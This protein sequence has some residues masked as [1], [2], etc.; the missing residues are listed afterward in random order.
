MNWN[1]STAIASHYDQSDLVQQQALEQ[2]QETE[3]RSRSSSA[4]AR[5]R[6]TSNLG[7]VPGD[8]NIATVGTGI[9]VGME[10]APQPWSFIQ[11]QI[12][13]HMR[14][15]S[16]DDDYNTSYHRLGGSYEDDDDEDMSSQLRADEYDEE[17]IRRPDPV[18]QQRLISGRHPNMGMDNALARAD[19]PSVE[20]IYEPPRHISFPGS[21]QE[22]KGLCKD[23][24]K[25]LIVNI[26]SH[27]EFSSHMLN[28]D[29]WADE[30][31]ESI[32]R[33]SFL[34][35][36]RGHTSDEGRMFMR[37]YQMSEAD[38]PNISIIDSRTGARILTLKG[39]ISH[40]DLSILLMEFLES[41][42]V[43]GTDA[44]VVRHIDTT[45]WKS[46][47]KEA[48]STHDDDSPV[49]IDEDEASNDEPAISSSPIAMDEQYNEPEA[50]AAE[51]SSGKATRRGFGIAPDEP[52]AS[53]ANAIKVSIK[54]ADG[55]K[56]Y[57]RRFHRNDN[58]RQLYA[59]V[60]EVA[61]HGRSFDLLSSY[62]ATSLFDK[63][64][65]TLEAAS[66]AGSQIIMRWL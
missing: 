58:V 46:H 49:P 43:D 28:R 37:T 32:L 41:N 65:A 14:G 61:G 25:W 3:R 29:T 13:S 60:D 15:D 64:D 52:N 53:D 62:P 16:E 6:S 36:Q 56:A 40:D 1:L 39:F 10:G 31:V 54:L 26:Q 7:Q 30:T 20:W 5:S 27:N 33:S 42:S 55:G 19:D 59:V 11:Q 4:M 38:L 66:L 34:F 24:K 45:K 63:M 44:P 23:E 57:V 47:E 35:W 50:A 21:F 48:A 51:I 8:E 2:Q 12:H 22:I 18:R 9:Q 17:G